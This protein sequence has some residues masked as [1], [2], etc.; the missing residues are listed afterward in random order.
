MMA[1]PRALLTYTLGGNSP[2]SL[3]PC[4]RSYNVISCFAHPVLEL[5]VVMVYRKLPDEKQKSQFLILPHSYEF[6]KR[7]WAYKSFSIILFNPLQLPD[8]NLL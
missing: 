6:L 4:P 2:S 3:I 7:P 8:V 1:Y 5:F